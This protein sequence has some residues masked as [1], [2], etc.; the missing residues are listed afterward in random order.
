MTLPELWKSFETLTVEFDLE[1]CYF[2]HHLCILFG[3]IAKC[4]E[5]CRKFL[6]E[7]SIFKLL[8]FVMIQ[9]AQI[10]GNTISEVK[11]GEGG[12]EEG[13]GGGSGSIDYLRRVCEQALLFLISKKSSRSSSCNISNDQTNYKSSIFFHILHSDEY[14]TDTDMF[15]SSPTYISSLCELFNSQD[16][17]VSSRGVRLLAILLG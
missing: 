12:E 10:V 1:L 9:S 15:I 5:D 3:R 11:E 14:E 17:G 4:D 6:F 7:C 2:T 8:C 13:G 16:V